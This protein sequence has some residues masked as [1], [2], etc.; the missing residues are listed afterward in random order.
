MDKLKPLVVAYARDLKV[1]LV[2]DVKSNLEFYKL[3]FGKYFAICN[4]AFNGQEALDMYN[5]DTNYYDLIVTDVEM[6]KLNGL[7]LVEKIREN[8]IDQHIIVITAVTDL[9]INQ[10]LAFHHIDGLLTKPV[11]NKKLFT[12]LYRILKNIT[13]KK[14]LLQYIVDL[15]NESNHALESKH[16]F[17]LIIQ[18][19]QPLINHKEVQEVTS[20]MKVLIDKSEVTHEQTNAQI[21][22]IQIS[23]TVKKNIRYTSDIVVSAQELLEDLD[24]SII[25][26]MEEFDDILENL[27]ISIDKFSETKNLSTM[28]YLHNT[29]SNIHLLSE[30]I[31]DIGLF[32]IISNSL[33][34]LINFLTNVSYDEIFSD[35][36]NKL[37]TQMILGLE[38]DL[39]KWSQ[40]IFTERDAP[41]V[42]Y[43][44]ASIAN[45]VLEI[46]SIFKN[47]D[48]ESDEDDLEFF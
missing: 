30:L 31:I 42:H 34:N 27:V 20:I 45:N 28:T 22:K 46:E 14:E 1:L 37:L 15:E 18:K 8:N 25:D 2:D 44:D 24:D 10:N 13:E 7:E 41:N 36:K 32:P 5:K 29:I 6:P 12:L 48:L 21:E 47:N 43:L 19:L 17:E 26:K 16:H 35:N 38:D 4:T 40:K 23:T 3:A 39:S 9:G 11:D 33:D